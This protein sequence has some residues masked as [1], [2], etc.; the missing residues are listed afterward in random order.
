[1]VEDVDDGLQ[2]AAPAEPERPREA[3]VPGEE[4]VLLAQGVAREDGTVRAD[5]LARAG[6]ALAGPR[7]PRAALLRHGLRR[8]EAD[9][10]VHE[11]RAREPRQHPAVEAVPLVAVAPSVLRVQ[12]VGPGVAEGEGIALVVV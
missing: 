11:D 5:P 4:L 7:V 8:R 12:P 6:G 3:H 2:R 1:E 9:A 10:V